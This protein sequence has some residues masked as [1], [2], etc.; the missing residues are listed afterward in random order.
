MLK[1]LQGMEEVQ[2]YKVK[3]KDLERQ[4]R[5]QW[6]SLS[7]MRYIKLYNED[8]YVPVWQYSHLL[9]AKHK[10][11]EKL[12]YTSDISKVPSDVI[13][14]QYTNLFNIAM[15]WQRTGLIEMKTARGKGNTILQL[16]ELYQEKALILV[17]NLKTLKE[18]REK[19]QKFTNY[20]PGY[21]SSKGK[22][23]KEIMITT[24]ASFVKEYGRR[25][26]K[27]WLVIYDEADVNISE[28]MIN[29]LS[30]I[31]AEGLFGFTGT[32][33]RQDLD[34]NDLQLI[35]WPLIKLEDQKNNGY[36]IIP[37]IRQLKYSK[38]PHSFEDF[39]DFRV[40]CIEDEDRMQKQVDFVKYMQPKTGLSLLLVDWVSECHAYK[41][42]LDKEKIPNVIINWETKIEDD[43]KNVKEMIDKHGVIIW[44][45]KKIGRWVDIPAVQTIYL[46]CP[47][48]FKSTVVQA[49]GRA[50]RFHPGKDKVYLFDWSDTTINQHFSRRKSYRDEYPDC[51]IKD[52]DMDSVDF[53][54]IKI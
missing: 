47:V 50:L 40:Q 11:S 23:E 1:K 20:D 32:P 53:S 31:D 35:Y 14:E 21:W 38:W 36:N 41:R 13:V 45:S 49:V 34:T 15:K 54:T 6:R 29:A 2:K 44:T 30:L 22:K 12:V 52:I 7:Y 16:I 17:H 51:K 9:S 3:N 4:E 27:F 24:H 26:G 19:F 28:K 18:M 46:F 25:A 33:Q 5:I 43:E 8:G 37:K 48:Q 42:L 10:L 39:H